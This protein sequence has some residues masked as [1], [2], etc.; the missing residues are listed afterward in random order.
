[1]LELRQ[2]PVLATILWRSSEEA[3]GTARGDLLLTFCRSCGHLYNSVFEPRLIQYTTNYDNSLHH[4]STFQTYIEDL[5]ESLV[6]RRSWNGKHVV[7]IGCG[8][9]DFLALLC[10]RANCTGTGFDPSYVDA[11]ASR[12][13]QDRITVIRDLYSSRYRVDA[14]L[15]V[16]RQVLEHL[17]EP[18][19]MLR[20]VRRSIGERADTAVFLEVPNAL[21]MLRARDPWELI[22]EHFSCFSPASLAAVFNA[23]GFDVSAVYELF[24]T[25]FLGIEAVPAGDG[26]RLAADRHSERLREVTALVNEFRE[27]A[28]A[29]IESWENRF[30]EYA[31]RNERVVVWGAGGR[32]TNFLNLVRRSSLVEYCVD[33]NP[34]KH[35][36]YV[37]GS[38]QKIVGPQFLAEYRPSVVVLLNPMYEREIAAALHALRVPAAIVHSKVPA[39]FCG[40]SRRRNQQ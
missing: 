5:V 23:A 18:Q 35:G 14:D 28:A 19:K 21:H 26:R 29:T 7:E 33:V 17:P 34:R 27:S 1:V 9:A 36:T 10:E 2:L 6:S 38:G 25:L 13:G 31:D 11:P 12:K 37:G 30:E 4:S 20:E 24:G 16:C 8:Q 15:F 40:A 22:Y 3:R 39:A 32:C